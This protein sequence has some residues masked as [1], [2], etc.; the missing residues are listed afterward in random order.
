MVCLVGTSMLQSVILSF[1]P[2][3]DLLMFFVA[4]YQ[5]YQCQCALGRWHDDDDDDNDEVC[6]DDNEEVD[7]HYDDDD[8][9]DDDDDDDD[10]GSAGGD[11]LGKF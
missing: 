6:D 1:E 3:N 7:D 4:L 5:C 8:A 9:D 10:D 2:L 11:V